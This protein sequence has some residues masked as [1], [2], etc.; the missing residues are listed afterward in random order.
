MDFEWAWEKVQVPQAQAVIIEFEVEFEAET[1][2][3][4]KVEA[5]LEAEEYVGVK[6][7]SIRVAVIVEFEGAGTGAFNLAAVDKG[8]GFDTSLSA[9]RFPSLG[10]HAIP[11]P[12][13]LSQSSNESK[14]PCLYLDSGRQ[15]V[16]RGLQRM[17]YSREIAS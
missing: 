1:L 6:V 9:C 12:N 5:I 3:P 15:I 14:I 16:Q 10:E 8:Q 17:L 7:A 13:C 4:L 2:A 11:V